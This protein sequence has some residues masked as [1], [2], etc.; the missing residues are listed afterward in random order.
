MRVCA[1]VC[2]DMNDRG[3]ADV[4]SLLAHAHERADAWAG[5]VAA[6]HLNYGHVQLAVQ[7]LRERD[8][9]IPAANDYYTSG[10][11]G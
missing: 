2:A 3:R 1:R 9:S 7:L 5:A 10:R 6:A 11:E 4:A 8:P